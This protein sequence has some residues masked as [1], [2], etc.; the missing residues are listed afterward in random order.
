[1]YAQVS[2]RDFNNLKV[3]FEATNGYNWDINTGWDFISKNRNDVQAWNPETKEGWYGLY[4][5]GGRVVG[6]I[7]PHNNLKGTLPDA[8][9]EFTVLEALDVKENKLSGSLPGNLG[10]LS[11]IYIFDISKNNF[12][13]KLPS[14]FSRVGANAYTFKSTR[15]R[16]GMDIRIMLTNNNFENIIPRQLSQMSLLAKPCDS[17]LLSFDTISA[18]G[19]IPLIYSI[20]GSYAVYSRAIVVGQHNGE[21]VYAFNSLDVKPN[22]KG[23]PEAFQEYV[24]SSINLNLVIPE[25]GVVLKFIIDKDGNMK[26]DDNLPVV[27]SPFER[28][29]ISIVL[30]SPKWKPGKLDGKP[31]NTQLILPL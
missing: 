18:S 17:Y 1:M 10:N 29:V 15:D 6:I 21:P 16:K 23:G 12:S 31:V 26:A 30:K 11:H 14:T 13:G 22:F 3:F 2:E 25:S 8:I 20:N 19:T 7:L 27:L 28:F 24:T 4:T 5:R 9:C